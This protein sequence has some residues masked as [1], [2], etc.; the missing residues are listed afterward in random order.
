MAQDKSKKSIHHTMSTVS[1]NAANTKLVKSFQSF[2]KM[3]KTMPLVG[4]I[5]AEFIGTFLITASFFEMQGN[6]LFFGFAI[7][8][9]ILVV[10]GVSGAYLN[11]AIT[12]GAFATRKISA[13]YAFV[14]ILAQILGAIAAW[15]VLNEFSKNSAATTQ[16]TGTVYHAAT[17]VTGK[18]WYLFYAELI[19]ATILSLGVATAIRLRSSKVVAAFAAGFA[20]LVAL[21]ITLSLTTVLLSEQG[22]SFTFLNPAIAIAANGLSWN[23]WPIAIYVVAPVIGAVIGFVLQDY[24]HSQTDSCDCDECK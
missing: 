22:T 4:V 2:C 6:P 9:T 14:Y 20:T 23:N 1:S 12:L 10:G 17:I 21:Y 16:L 11:P 5:V 8:G 19:G 7:I 13:L 18:E 3:V 24:L 15:A